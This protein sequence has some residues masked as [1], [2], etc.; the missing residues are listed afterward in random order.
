[1]LEC[2]IELLLDG[3]W[4]P[5]VAG[6]TVF[7]PAGATVFVPAGATHAFGNPD[8]RAA[9]QLVVGP[10]EVAEL[11]ESPREPGEEIHERQRSHYANQWGNSG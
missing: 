8:D 1:M 7:V 2:Q 6:M 10:V 9:R 4:R 11:D 5:A 3:Q